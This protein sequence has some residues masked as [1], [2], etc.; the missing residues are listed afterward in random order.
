MSGETKAERA[1]AN[2]R[3]YEELRAAGQE[4]KQLPPPT[5]RDGAPITANAII[6]TEQVPPG[7]HATMRLSR[8]EALRISD[9]LGRSSVSLLAWRSEDP[10]ER[11]NCADTVKV[12]WSAALSKGRMILSDMGRVLLSV[13]EDT[14]GA[15]D[16]LVGGS[17]ADSTLAAYG[18]VTRNTQANFISAAA[19]IGLGLRDIPPCVTFFAPVTTDANGRFVWQ[20]ARKRAGDFVDLRAEMNLIVAVSNCAHP[21]D[22][23]RPAATTPITLIRHRL[24]PP[25]DDDVC[26]RAS[27]EAV[28]AYAFTDQLFA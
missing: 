18:E 19:K 15:H 16:L 1:A 27:P 3:R 17:T 20:A 13:I 4:L 28:R 24:P 2:R 23:A 25:A 5:A 7:W 14:S 22:P 12:Q 6:Q 10:C 21:L 9:D 26:R 8:G 11:I